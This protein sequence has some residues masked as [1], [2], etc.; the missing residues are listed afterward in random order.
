MSPDSAIH[1]QLYPHLYM[2][3]DFLVIYVVKHK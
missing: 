1:L 2:K 3:G